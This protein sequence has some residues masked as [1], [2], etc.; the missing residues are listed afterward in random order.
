MIRLL[1]A[2]IAAGQQTWKGIRA[3]IAPVPRTA[4]VQAWIK[5][6]RYIAMALLLAGTAAPAAAAPA[7]C[8][9]VRSR[10]QILNALRGKT[11][12]KTALT[13]I[14][15]EL[16]SL[17]KE[18]ATL[19]TSQPSARPGI[20]E[21]SPPPASTYPGQMADYP[22]DEIERRR[23]IINRRGQP[24]GGKTGLRV[25][26]Q[27]VARAF[28]VEGHILLESGSSSTF[29]GKV[30]QE[31][32][33]S[34]LETF[35]G[36][37]IVSGPPGREGYT[38]QTLS[39]EI[40][41]DQFSG[42]ACAKYSSK[43][44]GCSQWQKI[45]LWQIGEGEEYPGRA[46]GVVSLTSD[47]RGVTLRIDVPV[48]EFG[49]SANTDSYRA[50]CIQSFRETVGL[51]EFKQW[52]RRS[53]VRQKWDVGKTIPGCRPGSTLTLELEFNRE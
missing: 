11:T 28:P 38:L 34:I 44:P 22:E 48:I 10:I 51:S 21:S 42:R 32:T 16:N 1:V 50:G 8:E 17:N 4:A 12:N 20:K 19:C 3:C 37:L 43:P 35:V 26:G 18:Q 52:L 46:D 23:E 5:S 7:T 49:S 25:P 36:N 45:D 2:S 27:P 31:L 53:K 39:T 14:Q 40:S 47:A 15:A 30:R 6:L 24:S 13:K 41:V 33:Y 9:S 29:Y